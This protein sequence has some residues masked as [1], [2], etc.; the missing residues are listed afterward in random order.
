MSKRSYFYIMANPWSRVLYAGVTGV[1]LVRVG[2]HKSK[3]LQRFTQKYKVTSLVHFQEFDNP[4]DAIAREREV[5]GWLRMIEATNPNWDDLSAGWYS[6]S[7]GIQQVDARFFVP[8][9]DVKDAPTQGLD[10]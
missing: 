6:D 8:Q 7:G 4:K 10:S 5:K 2:Q 3:Q 1:L 9:N